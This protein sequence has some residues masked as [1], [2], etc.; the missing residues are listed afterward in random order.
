MREMMFSPENI[1]QG[2]AVM[3]GPRELRSIIQL[4]HMG[5]GKTPPELA[6]IFEE[7]LK[8]YFTQFV[9]PAV[10]NT[11]ADQA[12][13]VAVQQALA[14]VDQLA[15]SQ[16]ET[17]RLKS[18]HEVQQEQLQNRTQAR[19]VPRPTPR[20]V[21]EF[22]GQSDPSELNT[23]RTRQQLMMQRVPQRHDREDNDDGPM[24]LRQPSR[25]DTDD[26][27][28]DDDETDDDETY[29][30]DSSDDDFE[31]PFEA[32]NIA[33]VTP[34]R[35]F[36]SSRPMPLGLP[37]TEVDDPDRYVP[38]RVKVVAPKAQ[39]APKPSGKQSTKMPHVLTRMPKRT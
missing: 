12:Q 28:T 25:A 32:T 6:D 5:K 26:D 9:R 24:Q 15:A 33:G 3:I 39:P 20:Q 10:P 14:I 16:A 36:T 29:D 27:D 18:Y 31:D 23:Q 19:T 30:E 11:A 35:P 7:E 22:L 34:P 8:S 37:I 17:Q 13:G 4:L 1:T 2:L 21:R 38:F